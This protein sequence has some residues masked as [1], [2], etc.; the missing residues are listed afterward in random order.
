MELFGAWLH[1]DGRADCTQC[2][3]PHKNCSGCSLHF[4]CLDQVAHLHCNTGNRVTTLHFHFPGAVWCCT[5]EPSQQG[6]ALH[7]EVVWV[8]RVCW[9]P[10]WQMGLQPLLDRGL[11]R[12]TSEMT[13]SWEKIA[14]G[15][16]EKSRGLNLPLHKVECLPFPS[17]VKAGKSFSFP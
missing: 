14:A 9:G 16:L 12:D 17:A 11:G 3:V 10:L 1:Q 13:S 6:C 7:C 5:T 4:C 15:S 2:S 8:L